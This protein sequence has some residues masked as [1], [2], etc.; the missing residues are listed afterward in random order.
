MIK[1]IKEEKTWESLHIYIYIV[2]LSLMVEKNTEDLRKK[3][4]Y[5]WKKAKR[6]ICGVDVGRRCV[7]S[8][9]LRL[10]ET[11][12]AYHLFGPCLTHISLCPIEIASSVSNFHDDSPF[13]ARF[14]A[15]FFIYLARLIK[16]NR[17]KT[18]WKIFTK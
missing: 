11:L 6:R 13:N 10:S 3:R 8:Q 15:I 2:F 5:R 7:I 4:S 14:S 18:K 12:S 9:S 1:F 16:T 17:L